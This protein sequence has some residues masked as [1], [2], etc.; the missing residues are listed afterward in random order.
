MTK[1]STCGK[2]DHR[3]WHCP[4]KIMQTTRYSRAEEL[5]KVSCIR[6]G[7]EDRINF[8]RSLTLELNFKRQKL[9]LAYPY[10]KD[11]LTYD[12]ETLDQLRK[13]YCI[14]NQHVTDVDRGLLIN[15]LENRS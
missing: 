11:L 12:I 5:R 9:L 7:E 15:I 14:H 3:H 1:C 8:L 4:E 13:R 6:R 10:E 2:E